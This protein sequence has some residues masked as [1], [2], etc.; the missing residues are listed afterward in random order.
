MSR[1]K[2]AE[3]WPPEREQTL[4]HLWEVEGLSSG[5][6]AWQMGLTRNAVI[7]KVTRLKLVKRVTKVAPRM[8]PPVQRKPPSTRFGQIRP[9]LLP[10]PLPGDLQRLSGA[11][12]S[13]LPGTQPV[14]LDDLSVGMCRWP[15][16]EGRPFLFCGTAAGAGVYCHHHH[17]LSIGR[18]TDSE[19]AAVRVLEKEAA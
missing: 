15:I 8:K 2:G 10:E 17:A 19:R 1:T 14:A 7:G 5:D 9:K 3:N 18:G 16:G 6:I 13:P 11:A 4:R 12:W